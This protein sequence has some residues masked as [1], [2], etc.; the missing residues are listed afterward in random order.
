MPKTSYKISQC[1]EIDRCQDT[2]LESMNIARLIAHQRP[3]LTRRSPVLE[4]REIVRRASVS[5]CRPANLYSAPVSGT[6]G[7]TAPLRRAAC[8][9][10]QILPGPL[11][12]CCF[13]AVHVSDT[14]VVRRLYAARRA[15]LLLA[16]S[17]NAG[18]Y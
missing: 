1:G 18:L 7:T 13:Y 12:H 2:G 11:M 9:A 10:S 15:L 17:S 16:G 6:P 8:T 4:S 5:L 14:P 3:L